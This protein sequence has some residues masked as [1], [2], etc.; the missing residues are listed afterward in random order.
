M[1]SRCGILRNSALLAQLVFFVSLTPGT[2]AAER[3]DT[4]A[5]EAKLQS[6]VSDLKSRLRITP[7]VVVSV[8]PSNT[9]MMSVEAPTDPKKA[10][11]LTID[12]SFLD[13]LSNDEL[14]AAI[15]HELGHVWIFTHHPYLQTEELAN[16]IA[17]RAVSR[18]SLARVYA[19]VWERG[20]TKGDLAR[21][22]GAQPAAT[23][24]A[25]AGL[26]SDPAR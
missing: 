18:E 16:Q 3:A 10:F 7:A 13:T 25:A 23:Q 24:P 14:E 26:A 9:L 1:R 21:F 6:L 2:F 19:K 22:L 20:G 11:L 5:I 8:V 12:A 4:P 15:A 17:M